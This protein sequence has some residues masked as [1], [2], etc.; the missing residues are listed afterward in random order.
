MTF[1]TV[2]ELGELV[3]DVP[4]AA[5]VDDELTVAI[6]RHQ[7]NLYAIEDE[8]SHG[9]VP[10][11]EGDVEGGTIECYLHG[12]RFDLAT[13][14]VL[15]LPATEPVRVFPVRIEDGNIQVDPDSTITDFTN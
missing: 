1:V 10:L 8:C 13:G 11:S 2:A 7:G 14:A 9:N 12:S 15:N 6:V 5:D 4:L 3:D